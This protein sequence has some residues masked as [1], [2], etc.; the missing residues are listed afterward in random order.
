MTAMSDSFGS[1]TYG[2]WRGARTTS[3]RPG[4]RGCKTRRLLGPNL[5]KSFNRQEI[6]E[7]VLMVGRL[8]V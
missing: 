4:A 5:K 3:L 8:M 6:S 7:T 2:N 1:K